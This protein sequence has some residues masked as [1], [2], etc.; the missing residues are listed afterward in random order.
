MI[1]IL[2]AIGMLAILTGIL[3]EG[4]NQQSQSQNSTKLISEVSSQIDYITSA[5]Q[6]CALNYPTQD[7]NMGAVQQNPPYPIIPNHTYYTTSGATPGP[8]NSSGSSGSATSGRQL[9]AARCPGNPGG[10]M[11]NSQNHAFI[12][13]GASGKF[14]PQPPN[15]IFPAWQYYAGADGVAI[16]FQITASDIYIENALKKLDAKYSQCEADYIDA[17]GGN[18]PIFTGGTTC[19]S[20]SQ[21]FIYR[22][23]RKTGAIPACP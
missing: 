15:N 2:L 18:I 20:G 14:I 13:G 4:G 21:C 9:V 5:L 23:I 10:T 6:E 7:A 19:P 8:A 16:Y 11:P 3:S 1:Y 22:L 17:R 12:F